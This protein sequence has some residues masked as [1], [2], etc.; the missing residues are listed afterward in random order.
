MW[1]LLDAGISE[2]CEAEDMPLEGMQ[3]NRGDASLA[4]KT[5]TTYVADSWL[6]EGSTRMAGISQEKENRKDRSLGWLP[7]RRWLERDVGEGKG[8]ASRM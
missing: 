6:H 4:P 1:V 5:E 8:K 2:E 7:G 3:S